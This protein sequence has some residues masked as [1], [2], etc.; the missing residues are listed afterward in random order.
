M[1]VGP[2]GTLSSGKVDVRF[3]GNYLVL[4]P[5]S[6]NFDTSWAVLP[7]HNLLNKVNQIKQYVV[8]NYCLVSFFVEE[9]P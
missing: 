5:D 4:Q 6:A 9:A 1:S 2:P 3:R 8:V 7:D